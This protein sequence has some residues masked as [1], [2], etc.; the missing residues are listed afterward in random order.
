MTTDNGSATAIDFGTP[1]TPAKATA[2]RASAASAGRP[3]GTPRVVSIGRGRRTLPAPQPSGDSTDI[4]PRSYFLGQLRRE[5]RRADRS[6]TALSVAVF[7][8]AQG[9]SPADAAAL[10]RT[11]DDARRETDIVGQLEVGTLAIICTDTGEAGVHS[12]IEKVNARAHGLPY[13]VE[14]AT[15]PDQLFE[16]LTSDPG[17]VTAP[18]S[19]FVTEGTPPG[20]GE[21]ALK[22]PLDIIGAFVALLLL[23]PLMLATA[24]AVRLSSPGPIIFRQTRLGRGGRPFAFYKFRSMVAGNNDQ[25]H[26]D[27][28][29]SLIN[30]ENQKVDQQAGAGAA[31]PLYKIK[32][33]PR[34]TPVGRF[35]RRTSIDE[36]PQLFNV[37]KGD[38]SLVGPRPPLP[39]EAENYRSWHLRRLLD[40]RPG[41]TGLWQV[42]GRSRVTFDEMVRMDLRYMRGCSLG[43]DLRLLAR[44]VMVVLRDDGAR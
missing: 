22:R 32:A 1:A 13:A 38:M 6:Q 16:G 17:V 27:Y 30:G 18:D 29:K 43:L 37:L 19:L 44:T 36:L 28:V 23:S 12:F 9:A 24:I 10:A 35:I 21:Y 2:G 7:R 8:L 14:S 33:D 39:Y 3:S 26:R 40:V 5:M 42:E 11:L 15:Y 20:S 34:I 41:I 31:G 4:L 25:I